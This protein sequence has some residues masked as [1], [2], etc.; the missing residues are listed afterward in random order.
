MGIMPG[1]VHS[2]AGPGLL[3]ATEDTDKGQ[4]DFQLVCPGEVV[5][6]LNILTDVLNE[7]HLSLPQGAQ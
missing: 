5:Q 7:G 4:A 2:T 6:W 1:V 3:G